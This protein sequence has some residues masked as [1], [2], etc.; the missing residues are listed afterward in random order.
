MRSYAPGSQFLTSTKFITI[1]TGQFVQTEN[2]MPTTSRRNLPGY[3]A[4]Q[5]PE[6]TFIKLP[7]NTALDSSGLS[8]QEIAELRKQVALGT[9]DLRMEA[10]RRKLDIDTLNAILAS[11]I[12]QAE[13]GTRVGTKVTIETKVKGRVGNTRVTISNTEPAKPDKTLA[14]AGIVAAIVIIAILVIGN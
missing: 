11:L 9:I 6:E 1:Q 14:I 4:G 10:A 12:D 3:P 7:D 5:L 8:K 2:L 13:D